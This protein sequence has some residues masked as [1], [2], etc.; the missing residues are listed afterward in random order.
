MRISELLKKKKRRVRVRVPAKL[1]EQL[2]GAT[3]LGVV[4]SVYKRGSITWVKVKLN[5]KAG[6][7]H[8]FRPQDLSAA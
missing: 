5:G 6:L 4:Q 7:T 2:G 1:Q 3:R 8:D